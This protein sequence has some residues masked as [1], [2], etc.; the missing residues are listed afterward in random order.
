MSD[1]GGT[2]ALRVTPVRKGLQDRKVP[3]AFKEWRARRDRPAPKG[4]KVHKAHRVRKGRRATK[5]RQAYLL[6]SSKWTDKQLAKA[7]RS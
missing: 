2:P 5:A 3:K 4:R 6:V 1:A 7:M